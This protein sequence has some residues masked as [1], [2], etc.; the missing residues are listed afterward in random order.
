MKKFLLILIGLVILLALG[1]TGAGMTSESIEYENRV[2]IDA[3]PEEI[4]A[5]FIDTDG[6]PEWMGDL[7][8]V[9]NIS[10]APLEV[11][12]SWTLVYGND[13]LLETVTAAEP[14]KLY[15]FDM[16][17]DGFVGQAVVRLEPKDGGTELISTTKVVAHNA[18]KRGLFVAMKGS[19]ADRTQAQYERL[20]D[21][22]ENPG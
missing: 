9:E 7:D 3:S 1:V 12:S 18:F 16:Q 19:F 22:I 15:A 17:T 10:G 2:L 8:S 21:V 5:R 4:W 14:G 13:E 20:K 11:G 6:M